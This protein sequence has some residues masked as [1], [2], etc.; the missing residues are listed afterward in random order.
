MEYILSAFFITIECQI[1][2]NLGDAFF[3]KN[4][5]SNHI[6]YSLIFMICSFV[7]MNFVVAN[8]SYAKAIIGILFMCMLYA[9]IYNG[10][11]LLKA[12]AS[13]STYMLLYAFD[14]LIL[15]FFTVVMNI[16]INDILMNPATYVIVT[17]TSK[18]SLYIV[19]FMAKHLL[20][21]NTIGANFNKRY[22]IISVIFPAFS[23]I[24]LLILFNVSLISNITS[25]WIVLDVI[26]IIIAN[27]VVLTLIDQIELSNKIKQENIILEQHLKAELDNLEV[28]TELYS[29]Q[30][31]MTHD[32]KN[33]L[34]AITDMAEKA[35]N[36]EIKLYAQ[37][38]LDEVP[39][40]NIII[41]TNNTTVNSI[42]N[43]K[44]Y[45][46][47]Q[48]N[49][50][51]SFEINDL[52]NLFISDNDIV[53]II[54]N[55]LDNAIEAS[56]KV[57]DKQIRLKI[58]NDDDMIT[59]SVMNTSEY[60]AI[61]NNEI[62]KNTKDISHGFGLKNIRTA[63]LKYNHIFAIDYNN[64]WFQLAIIINEY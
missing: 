16:S 9:S 63:L 32:Y 18:F 53:T 6:L 59:I 50:S 2:L 8:T 34:I 37:K 42:I 10:K 47:K 25:Y 39:V 12:F 14:Y 52:K 33:H 13:V 5:K 24:T 3:T 54:A 17:S 11:L 62:I 36:A 35:R 41:D 1:I 26:G 55:A 48:Q 60:V 40:S 61:K 31:K 29:A 22:F 21:N 51:M 44:Y 49:I 7:I 28:V 30:R 38:L 64:G 56:S 46:A 20:K 27:I 58:I 23:M 19:S 15:A 4:R 57:E 45:R 43:Q